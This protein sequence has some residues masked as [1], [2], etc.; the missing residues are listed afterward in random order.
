MCFFN[1][2]V[3]G[4]ECLTPFMKPSC[5][6][7]RAGFYRCAMCCV[8][9]SARLLKTEM[10]VI[11]SKPSFL[12]SRGSCGR[13]HSPSKVDTGDDGVSCF[14]NIFSFPTKRVVTFVQP[15][16]RLF[17]CPDVCLRSES[18]TIQHLEHESNDTDS[19]V[20]RGYFSLTTSV[21]SACS[22]C[23]TPPS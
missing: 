23:I 10:H 16:A 17:L 14:T 2:P 8:P 13:L 12:E 6:N 21:P 20:I 9:P 7:P 4:R 5:E 15:Q 22:Q 3:E 18:S 1:S 11:Y 19:R